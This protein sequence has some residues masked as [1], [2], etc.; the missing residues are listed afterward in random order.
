MQS[1]KMCENET[2]SQNIFII[3]ETIFIQKL[4]SNK[5]FLTHFNC[6]HYKLITSKIT[7]RLINTNKL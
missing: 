2:D 1:T 7:K 5:K 3:S 6:V 4:P